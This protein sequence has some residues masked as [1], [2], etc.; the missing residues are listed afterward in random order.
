VVWQVFHALRSSGRATLAKKSASYLVLSLSELE[1][2]VEGKGETPDR[3][4]V[5]IELTITKDTIHGRQFRDGEV[6]DH[7]EGSYFLD[8]SANP[9]TL[10]GVKLR[11]GRNKDECLGI[12]SL[13]ADTLKWC[14]RKRER[15]SEFESKDKAFLLILERQKP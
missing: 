7:G 6:I 15:P 13:E 1:F 2:A 3:G 5:K 9:P 4:P 11:G 10:D 12:Y 14:V 8:L